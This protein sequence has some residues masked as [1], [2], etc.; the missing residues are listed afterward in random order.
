MSLGVTN[1]SNYPSAGWYGF[2]QV[3]YEIRSNL[4]TYAYAGSSSSNTDYDSDYDYDFTNYTSTVAVAYLDYGGCKEPNGELNCSAAC[5]D[6]T[7][8][9]G[10]A[11]TLSN[12]MLYPLIAS[13]YGKGLLN[14]TV[15]ST[16]N[17]TTGS[18][19]YTNIAPATADS[20]GIEPDANLNLSSAE[21][22][23]VINRCTE[24]YCN[25]ISADGSNCTI[26]DAMGW[27]A[28]WHISDYRP[29]LHFNTTLCQ[30]INASINQ[31][32]GGV[33]MI[34]AYLI[35]LSILLAGWMVQGVNSAG[36]A[37]F[38]W[39]A[40]LI[41]RP[42]DRGNRWREAKRLQRRVKHSRQAVAL[43]ATLVEF[44]RTQT[45]FVLAVSV[46][47]LLAV[48]NP[49]YLQVASYQQLWNNITFISTIALSGCYPVVL[50]LLILRKTG[51]SSLY[52]LCIST[53]CAV[54]ATALWIRT[55]IQQPKPGQMV[56]S[57]GY[58]LPE[59]GTDKLT[60][61]T[62]T[63]LQ[64]G[65]NSIDGINADGTILSFPL[66]V[67]LFL[68]VEEAKLFTALRASNTKPDKV[69]IF[70]YTRCLLELDRSPAYHKIA[71]GCRV[72]GAWLWAR[73]PPRVK[74]ALGESRQGTRSWHRSLTWKS[75]DASSN[76][77]FRHPRVASSWSA[78]NARILVPGWSWIKRMFSNAWVTTCEYCN[79]H[80]IPLAI[81]DGLYKYVPILT[82]LP[83]AAIN[84]VLLARYASYMGLLKSGSWSLGQVISVTI[85]VPVLS[86]YAYLLI[87]GIEEGFE[88][89][90]A[91]PYHVK[92][93]DDDDE[94]DEEHHALPINNSGDDLDK[95]STR[96]DSM[97]KLPS[98]EVE[99][100]TPKPH[101]TRSESEMTLLASRRSW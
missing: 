49:T 78:L 86:E 92:K 16:Y 63:C 14:Y 35:Q 53:C 17:R 56:P 20:F 9:W 58:H 4:G 54:V 48:S 69:S 41:G 79:N 85:W 40:L 51:H 57:N 84:G 6:P 32:L 59:C 61:P 5:A 76:L 13:A 34:I 27:T 38:V 71:R 7:R 96:K 22:W 87:C 45:F 70:E 75:Q 19:T 68:V 50:N 15:E 42:R 28:K 66:A 67:L 37:V 72:G 94:E 73:T 82:E 29:Q 62:W 10:D 97:A 52:L 30:G 3:V 44:Q 89:R 11:A 43:K 2:E 18:R 21:P 8:V 91:S 39:I 31:D 25:A 77:S 55:V 93:D 81:L 36:T 1:V 26:T 23:K 24:A 101:A 47:A 64:M 98:D 46:A 33:G 80:N 90:L 99:M 95:V 74:F 12:C 100:T 83:L 88:Y 65:G 60:N